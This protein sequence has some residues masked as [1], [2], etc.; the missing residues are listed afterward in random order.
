[1]FEHIG[2]EFRGA[3]L[4]DARRSVRLERIC[5]ALVCDPAG[6]FPEAMG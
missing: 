1:M 4:G 3:V 6:S 5:E 2:E